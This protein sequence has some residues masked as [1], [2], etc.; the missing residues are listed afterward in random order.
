MRAWEQIALSCSDGW[1]RF[2]V[3]T[4]PVKA[5]LKLTQF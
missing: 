3:D 4:G 1:E 2:V 5:S